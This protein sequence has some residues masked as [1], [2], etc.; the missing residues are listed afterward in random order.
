[1][2]VSEYIT[3]FIVSKDIKHIFGY[4]GTMIAYLIDAIYKNPNIENHS[5][6]N[7]QAAAFAAVGYAK[8]SNKTGVAYATSGPG[9]LNLVSGVADAYYDSVPTLFITGQL[10]T[11]EYTDVPEL[12]QQGF[13]ETDV[14]GI[15]SPITKYCI[16]IKS[17]NEIAF[18]L[19]K[20]WYI[21][22]HGRKGPVLLDIPMNI[23]RTVIN[24]DQLIHFTP[25]KNIITDYDLIADEIITAIKNS[26]RPIFLFGNGIDKSK[27]G[28]DLLNAFINE[29]GIPVITSIL[30]KNLISY[31]NEY[32]LGFLGAAYGQR[33]ANIVAYRK[34]DLIISFGCSMNRRQTG[35][36]SEKFAKNAKIIRI[37]IDP[38][39]LKRK[40]HA[41]EKSFCVDANKVINEIL[42]RSFSFD[43][44]EWKS[45]C[46][47][48]KKVTNDFESTLEERKPNKLIELL[49]QIVPENSI[50]VSDVGQH[51]MWMAQSF[52]ISKNKQV[53]F[54]GGHGA[55]GFALPAG[56]G[57]YYSTN[58]KLFVIAGDGAFQMNIQELQ[59]VKR[60][61]IPLTMIV[62]NNSSLGLIRQQQDDFF[63]GNRFA[64]TIEG[65]YT[66]PDFYKIGNAYGIKSY[67]V[68]SF[69][70]LLKYKSEIIQKDYPVLFEIMID[71][72]S[73][74][75][76]KTYFGEKMDNQRPYMDSLILEELYRM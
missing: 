34:A 6:Y 19:E 31:D 65:G 18:C 54:S 46:E 42:S 8:S 20:A 53:I 4:Q 76:P 74:A 59:W 14:I 64:S 3:Q 68:D 58:E 66:A 11:N 5:C 44:S 67:R 50:S 27:A 70:E 35:G 51:Q 15:F 52:D 57:S 33:V 12:R 62:L 9:A 40:V 56:I 23:Q 17:A 36:N 63:D 1:M 55:M 71:T 73:K 30:G 38:V 26:K 10:N 13:Q 7:E 72:E 28:K 25:E 69:E 39:E 49:S 48:I 32:Y 24:T 29:M 37:D 43:F 21:A 60:E 75:Y 2:N 47:Q 16:Q 45:V 41:D 61:N 22:N